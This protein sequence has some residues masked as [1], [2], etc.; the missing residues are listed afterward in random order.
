MRCLASLFSILDDEMLGCW[1]NQCD[2]HRDTPASSDFTAPSNSKCDRLKEYRIL[3]VL[4]SLSQDA[5]TLLTE[6]VDSLSESEKADVLITWQWLRNRVWTLA[7]SHGLTHRADDV[8]RMRSSPELSTD[9]LVDVALTT[10]E[11]C[12]ALSFSSMESHGRG[13]VEKLYDIAAMP[14]TLLLDMS[15]QGLHGM[16]TDLAATDQWSDMV[17]ALYH[18]V[19]RHRQGGDLAMPLGL[20]LLVGP[21]K[22]T[23]AT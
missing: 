14:T 5:H 20:A 15:D 11:L 16:L 23:M 4:R 10:V 2:V 17:Q 18:F 12:R 7:H 9:Y 6:G 3:R 1:T 22:P 8:E 21:S 13:F 19:S